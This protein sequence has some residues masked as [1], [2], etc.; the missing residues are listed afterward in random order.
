MKK[1]ICKGRVELKHYVYISG[2]H[3]VHTTYYSHVASFFL[4]QIIL[5]FKCLLLL[6]VSCAILKEHITNVSSVVFWMDVS[7]RI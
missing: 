5:S 6:L 7:G 1:K 2:I 3:N 4:L